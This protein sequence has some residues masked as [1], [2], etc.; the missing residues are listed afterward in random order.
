MAETHKKTH[1]ADVLKALSGARIF[2][3]R[4]G[5]QRRL[6]PPKMLSAGAPNITPQNMRF[7]GAPNITGPGIPARYCQGTRQ[8]YGGSTQKNALRRRARD[9]AV[10]G[11]TKKRT[12]PTREGC[13]CGRKCFCHNKKDAAGNTY[14]VLS[15]RLTKLWRK[16]A[17]HSRIRSAEAKCKKKGEIPTMPCGAIL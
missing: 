13:G 11:N 2:S 7:A 1:F 4:Q 14:M 3:Q 12:S 5:R 17:A 8:S 6:T 9:A 16:Q 10:G 15:R